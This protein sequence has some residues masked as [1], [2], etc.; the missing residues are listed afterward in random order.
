MQLQIGTNENGEK[1]FVSIVSTLANAAWLN[2]AKF[3]GS[4][5]SGDY[6]YFLFQEIQYEELS[7]GDQVFFFL[8]FLHRPPISRTTI[9]IV[10]SKIHFS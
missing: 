9:I 3:V 2:K 10:L 6:A 7:S 4:F 1:A 8:T 5:S